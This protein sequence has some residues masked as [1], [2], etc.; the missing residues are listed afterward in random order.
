M[1]NIYIAELV[2]M[3]LGLVSNIDVINK[4]S[5]KRFFFTVH[6]NGEGGV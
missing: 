4:L 1:S 3:P 6:G 2:T 5:G